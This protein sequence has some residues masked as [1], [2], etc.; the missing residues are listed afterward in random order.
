LG[1]LADQVDEL[2]GIAEPR[3]LYQDAV[4][5]LAL[6]R[7]LDQAHGVHAPPDDLNRLV[8]DLAD[9]LD[10]RR[11]GDCQPDEATAGVLDV[12]RALTARAEETRERL[13]K[14]AQL[15]Q[16]LLLVVVTQAYLDGIAADRRRRRDADAVL[17]QHLAHGIEE[18][19]QLL[20]TYVVD[21]DLEQ[22]VRPALQVEPEHDTTLRPF[23]P[24]LDCALGEEI[25]HREQAND[26]RREENRRCFPL[27]NVQ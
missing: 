17:A 11:L 8:D 3:H 23:R 22:Y 19:L 16:S 6:D 13:R 25:G 5:A 20:A 14:L 4:V 1:G 26:E 10:D 21:I 27:R 7:R 18:R 24:A 12:E 2:L 9:A 15:G